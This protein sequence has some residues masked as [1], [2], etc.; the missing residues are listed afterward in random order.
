MTANQ[1]S[2][3]MAR[4]LLVGLFLGGLLFWPATIYGL[5]LVIRWVL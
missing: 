2:D 5:I 3:A 1:K 4:A